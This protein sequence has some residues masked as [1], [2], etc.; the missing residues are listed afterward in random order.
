[1]R[2]ENAAMREGRSAALSSRLLARQTLAQRPTTASVMVSPISVASARA[3]RSASAAFTPSAIVY[4]RSRV[5][6]QASR[7]CRTDRGRPLRRNRHADEPYRLW[8]SNR[9]AS[10]AL[11]ASREPLISGQL[12]LCE[13]AGRVHRAATTLFAR[14]AIRA[15]S[16]RGSCRRAT[17]STSKPA[18]A[19]P[20]VSKA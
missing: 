11:A 17:A 8:W 2:R 1:M 7:Y 13:S 14:V 19:A 4:P 9:A 18:S 3:S 12:G 16:R 20:S 6:E 5:L 15:T 10:P